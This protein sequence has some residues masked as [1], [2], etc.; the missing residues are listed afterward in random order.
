M[1]VICTTGGLGTH[2]ARAVSY[3]LFD[4]AHPNGEHR[5]LQEMYEKLADGHGVHSAFISRS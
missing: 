3:D 2:D 5:E 4:Q 1:G